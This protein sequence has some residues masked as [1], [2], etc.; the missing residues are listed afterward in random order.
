MAQRPDCSPSY[1]SL[2]GSCNTLLSITIYKYLLLNPRKSSVS[3][4]R[5]P[6]VLELGMDIRSERL[7]VLK[8]NPC[9]DHVRAPLTPPMT[10][11]RIK[12]SSVYREINIRPHKNIDSVMNFFET[13][14][15]SHQLTTRSSRKPISS[16]RRHNKTQTVCDLALLQEPSL[17]LKSYMGKL[18]ISLGHVNWYTDTRLLSFCQLLRWE[19][20][21]GGDCIFHIIGITHDK[22]SW[23]LDDFLQSFMKAHGPL[24]ISTM[25]N[26][27]VFLQCQMTFCAAIVPNTKCISVKLSKAN[28]IQLFFFVCVLYIKRTRFSGEIELRYLIGKTLMEPLSYASS[29]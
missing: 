27:S 13:Y 23:L 1:D 12:Y 19:L 20:L 14:E 24:K 10:I 18:S 15:F 7:L 26:W 8:H 22:S 21:V 3:T 2:V 25:G 9:S 11:V 17:S 28:T 4:E 5:S 6:I 29:E 16:P